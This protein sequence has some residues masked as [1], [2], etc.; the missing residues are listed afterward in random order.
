MARCFGW[1][2]LSFLPFMLV[3]AEIP[4]KDPDLL[5][6]DYIYLHLLQATLGKPAG[7]DNTPDKAVQVAENLV[8]IDKAKSQAELEVRVVVDNPLKAQALATL[9]TQ[10]KDC[11]GVWVYVYVADWKGNRVA[12]QALPTAVEEL[13]SLFSA[14][15]DSNWYLV[16]IRPGN[17]FNVFFVEL[18]P[19]VVQFYND[20]LSN[21]LRCGNRTPED[22][23]GE[24][25]QIQKIRDTDI[26]VGITTAL[27]TFLPKCQEA[28][29][30]PYEE[31]KSISIRK[32][33]RSA[34]SAVLECLTCCWTASPT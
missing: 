28:C 27:Q 2:F 9:I 4:P 26:L 6:A 19:N 7:Y 11:A 13:K 34:A 8:F 25:F 22:V 21:L 20:S 29:P 3:A 14:A 24:L 16:S 30:P 33:L 31:M 18:M 10:V 17:K 32:R 12:P 15:L 23:F 1:L 5:Q